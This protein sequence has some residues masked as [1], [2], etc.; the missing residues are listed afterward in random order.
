MVLVKKLQRQRIR[1]AKRLGASAG[2]IRKIQHCTAGDCY[3]KEAMILEMNRE[4]DIC[5]IKKHYDSNI[6]TA[7]T[8]LHGSISLGLVNLQALS[9]PSARE[10]Q[11][12]ELESRRRAIYVRVASGSSTEDESSVDGDDGNDEEGQRDESE[13]SY[14]EVSTP[15]ASQSFKNGMRRV[16]HWFDK[17]DT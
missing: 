11:M 3:K 2:A 15:T 16:V 8:A 17:M 1:R 4:M 9:S 5:P 12:E 7:L 6:A 10:E 14:R 13:S